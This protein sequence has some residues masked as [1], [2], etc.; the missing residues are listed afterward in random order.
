M[1][2]WALSLP[3]KELCLREALAVCTAPAPEHGERLMGQKVLTE[4][5]S[6]V[7]RSSRREGHHFLLQEI[8]PTQG[9]NPGE[10]ARDGGAWWAAVYGVA[11]SRT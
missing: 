4:S 11:Q 7:R 2:P 6:W 9:L 3:D 8:F 1:Q 5:G 10:N